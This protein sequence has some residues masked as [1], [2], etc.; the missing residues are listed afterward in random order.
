MFP[1]G[2]LL[3]KMILM[4]SVISVLLISILLTSAKA[5]DAPK[6]AEYGQE[7]LNRDEDLLLSFSV[8]AKILLIKGNY[9]QHFEAT[10]LPLP[11]YPVNALNPGLIGESIISFTIAEDGHA[12]AVHPEKSTNKVFEET[13]IAAVSQWVFAPQSY[14]GKPVQRI[15]RVTFLFSKY[16]QNN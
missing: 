5:G 2:K 6:K 3:L 7:I 13:S 4:K 9:E 12:I 1:L 15:A 16:E 10:T 11:I 14:R 8:H